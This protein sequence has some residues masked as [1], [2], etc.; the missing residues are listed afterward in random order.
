MQY[1]PTKRSKASPGDAETV[2]PVGGA[3]HGSGKAA[4]EASPSAAASPAAPR[5]RGPPLSSQSASPQPDSPEEQPPQ[6]TQHAVGQRVE[7]DGEGEEEDDEDDGD[8]LRTQ[9]MRALSEE[10]DGEPSPE[11]AFADLEPEQV[12]SHQVPLLY[13]RIDGLNPRSRPVEG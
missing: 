12:P 11:L 10:A 5:A 9:H 3:D 13:A 4:R 8:G 2:A 7:S 6:R 1:I